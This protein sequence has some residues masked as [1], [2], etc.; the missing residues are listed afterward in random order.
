MIDYIGGEHYANARQTISGY[1][2][3]LLQMNKHVDIICKRL[4]CTFEQ[5][6]CLVK[7]VSVYSIATDFMSLP[8][9]KV[10]HAFLR[11]NSCISIRISQILMENLN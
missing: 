2:T 5:N 4:K 6:F 7:D 1:A 8:F 3:F 11:R 9:G 10:I